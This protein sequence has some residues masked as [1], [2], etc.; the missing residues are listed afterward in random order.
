MDI[1]SQQT[2][3][4]SYPIMEFSR[5]GSHCHY[6][7][8][9]QL[10]FLHF[11]CASCEE[12]YCLIHRLP[13][14]HEC[15]NNPIANNNHTIL[16]S[17]QNQNHLDLDKAVKKL[18]KLQVNQDKISILITLLSKVLRNI[19]KHPDNSN[20]RRLKCESKTMQSLLDIKVTLIA[21]LTITR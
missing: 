9:G 13:D 3:K 15:P 1:G 6:S 8:C 12:H 14:Q 18:F 17:H 5:I 4:T 19:I 16:S 11:T 7:F 20:Y 2:S 21:T 10:D